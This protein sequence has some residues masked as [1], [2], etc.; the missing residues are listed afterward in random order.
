MTIDLDF[1][2]A[3]CGI[4]QL[5]ARYCDAV[6]R[7]DMDAFGDCFAQDCE[8]RMDGV[9]MRGREEIVAQNKALFEANFQRLLIRLGT[10]ILEVGRGEAKGTASART[11][12]SARNVLSDGTGFAPIDIYYEHFV[13]EGDRW[14]FKWRRFD[15]LYSGPA[16]M[17]GMLH[18]QQDYGAP[19]AMPPLDGDTISITS[20]IDEVTRPG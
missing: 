16:D 14:R 2:L 3:E 17:S 11:Y 19:P 4:R 18:E 15:G 10:P 7:F 8:W 13:D 1:L 6:W 20:L 9:V 5:H 12:F